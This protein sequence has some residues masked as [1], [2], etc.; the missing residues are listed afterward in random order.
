MNGLCFLT[1]K[2]FKEMNYT[3]LY[4]RIELEKTIAHRLY[5][6]EKRVFVLLKGDDDLQ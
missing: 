5:L 1:L 2:D 4:Q 6:P 3:V